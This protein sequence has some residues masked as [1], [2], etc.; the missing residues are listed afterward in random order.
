MHLPDFHGR[1]VTLVAL[2]NASWGGHP[3]FLMKDL[4]RVLEEEEA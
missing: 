2:C 4:L 3:H 1:P